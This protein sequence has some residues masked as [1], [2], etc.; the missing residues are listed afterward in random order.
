MANP[1]KESVLESIKE[2]DGIGLDAF[3]KKYGTGTRSY[4]DI[5]YNEKTYLARAIYTRAYN[6]V[7]PGKDWNFR[8]TGGK[9]AFQ[10]QHRDLLEELGFTVQE[11]LSKTQE[12][13]TKSYFDPNLKLATN[14]KAITYIP[15]QRSIGSLME[16][17]ENGE[18]AT[19][20]FTKTFPMETCT[21]QHIN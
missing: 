4:Y 11:R 1:T 10:K 3:A 7:N 8:D 9:R 6:L 18:L 5:V 16:S 13:P 20:G 14:T 15:S 2:Y 19:T 21:N 17:L 12:K